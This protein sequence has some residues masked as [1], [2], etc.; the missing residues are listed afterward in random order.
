MRAA[1][2]KQ[3][4]NLEWPNFLSGPVYQFYDTREN[5]ESV[6]RNA[7]QRKLRCHRTISGRDTGQRQITLLGSVPLRAERPQRLRQLYVHGSDS[8]HTPKKDE[9]EW[10]C[11][12]DHFRLL[13]SRPTTDSH[14]N[15]RPF[16]TLP[17][18]IYVR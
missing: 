7:I 16:I 4:I 5:I 15:N 18:R 2:G 10:K 6:S 8:R 3:E 1:D 17:R 11:Y 9:H 13:V 12:L 14:Q